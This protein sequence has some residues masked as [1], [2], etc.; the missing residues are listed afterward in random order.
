MDALIAN[1]NPDQN[2]MQKIAEREARTIASLLMERT[3][4]QAKIESNALNP[5]QR[6]RADELRKN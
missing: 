4:L 5:E 6:A 2:D 3:R 1:P